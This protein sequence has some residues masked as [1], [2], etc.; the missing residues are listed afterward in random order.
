MTLVEQL[1]I[2]CRYTNNTQEITRL[3]DLNVDPNAMWHS[4]A[5]LH[6]ACRMAR[7]DTVALLL[8]RHADIDIANEGQATPLHYAC[9]YSGCDRTVALLIDRRACLDAVEVA[10][11]QTPLHF[12]VLRNYIPIAMLL[13]DAG[14]DVNAANV[15]I[16]R[17]KRPYWT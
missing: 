11:L 12:A 13:I 15:C 5:P 16:D 4:W 9:Y 2:A 8:D 3:L 7:Y 10:Y 1:C 6:M 17:S 14:A